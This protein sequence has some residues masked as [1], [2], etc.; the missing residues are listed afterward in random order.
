MKSAVHAAEAAACRSWGGRV[1]AAVFR[2]P[3]TVVFAGAMV[4]AVFVTTGLAREALQSAGGPPMSAA[5]SRAPADAPAAAGCDDIGATRRRDAG[6]RP[7][8]PSEAPG[9][10]FTAPPPIVKVV[11]RNGSQRTPRPTVAARAIDAGAPG[12]GAP[13]ARVIQA[14]QVA[15]AANLTRLCRLQL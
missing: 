14:I 13:N 6:R 8:Q 5:R 12:A 3:C 9:A 15:N 7:V 1:V 4:A 10:A 2:M 11:R